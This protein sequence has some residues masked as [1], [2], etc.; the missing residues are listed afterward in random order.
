MAIKIKNKSTIYAVMRKDLDNP[1]DVVC[2][3][4]RTLDGAEKFCGQYE[5]AFEDSGGSLDDAYFY[6]VGNTF[7]DE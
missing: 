1:K 6:V 4:S 2:C 3:F 5:Q 7:Y